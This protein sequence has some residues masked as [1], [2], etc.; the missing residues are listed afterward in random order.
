MQQ[1]AERPPYVRFERRPIEIPGSAIN[2]GAPSFRDVDYALITPGGSKDVVEREVTDWFA[3]IKQAAASNRFPIAWVN[4][5]Q[6]QYKAWKNDEELP[7]T[8]TPITHW[9]G[10]NQAQ[11]TQLRALRYL[12]VED[13]AAMNEE[14]I[15]RMGMGGRA[16]KQRAEAFLSA[17]TGPAAQAEQFAALRVQNE[18]LQA[19]L[20]A[21][22]EQIAELLKLVPKDALTATAVVQ[23]STSLEGS[24]TGPVRFKP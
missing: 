22:S 19:Q 23:P 10:L 4:H 13:V 21:Q 18:S 8:G 7:I 15:A 1:L 5:F 11:L 12:T 20:K 6:E 17:K 3:Y 2:D 14:G 24:T 16:L 9:P